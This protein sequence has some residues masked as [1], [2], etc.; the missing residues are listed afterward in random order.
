MMSVAKTSDYMYCNM[1]LLLISKSIIFKLVDL[2]SAVKEI[3][4][5]SYFKK[6]SFLLHGKTI[7]LCLRIVLV[8]RWGK[9]AKAKN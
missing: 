2:R 4:L 6:L 7:Y 9:S 3:F 8:Q 1:V 5:H